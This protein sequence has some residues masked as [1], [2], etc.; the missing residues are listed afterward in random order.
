[1]I[2]VSLK[3]GARREDV[4]VFECQ[5]MKRFT[6]TRPIY[7]GSLPELSKLLVT[8]A[9]W[10][11]AIT[12]EK[13]A[14]Q[15]IWCRASSPH[16]ALSPFWRWHYRPSFMIFSARVWMPDVVADTKLTYLGSLLGVIFTPRLYT[17]IIARRMMQH[18][19]IYVIFRWYLK[20]VA[21]WWLSPEKCY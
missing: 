12:M 21:I 11:W 9:S 17:Y 2:F 14:T 20:M 8:D 13:S 3:S 18:H 1:M 6:Y 5:S 19:F 15:D 10:L 16:H 4:A 7:L